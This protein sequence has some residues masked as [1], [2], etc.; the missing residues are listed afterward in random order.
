MIINITT[1]K[2]HAHFVL[3]NDMLFK[4]TNIL[5]L[6]NVDL[7][8]FLTKTT[9]RRYLIQHETTELLEFLKKRQQ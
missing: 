5:P 4:C 7:Q 6:M 9:F 8:N 1:I 3:A 2:F